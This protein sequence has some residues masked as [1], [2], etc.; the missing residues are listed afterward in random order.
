MSGGAGVDHELV[1]RGRELARIRAFVTGLHDQAGALVVAGAPGAGKTALLDAGAA[2]AQAAGH[3]VVRAAGVRL[4]TGLAY[5][6]LHQILFPLRDRFAALPRP[7]R[8][9]LEIGLGQRPGHRVIAEAMSELWR[10]LSAGRPLLVI[11]DDLPWVDR[12][13]AIVLSHVARGPTGGFLGASRAGLSS[14]F[15]PVGLPELALDP[16]DDAAAEDLLDQRR[17]KLTAEARKRVRAEARGNPLVLLE[18]PAAPAA[19]PRRLREMFTPH[20]R[21]LTPAARRLLLLAAL[22]TTGDQRIL[23]GA[24]ELAELDR[25][26]LLWFDAGRGRLAFRHPLVRSTVL[27]TAGGAELR[28]AHQ[29]LASLFTDQPDRSAWHLAE[30]TVWPDESVAGMLEESARSVLLRGDAVRAVTALERAAGLSP[31]R[32]QR[33]RRLAEAAYLGADLTGGLQ[34]AAKLLADHATT[35]NS[36][37]VAVAAAHVLLNGD[38]DIDTAHRLLVEAI[39]EPSGAFLEDALYTLLLICFFG[40]RAALWVPLR[41]A[42]DKWD[43]QVTA[44]VRLSADTLAD[45]ARTSPAT[46]RRLDTAIEALAGESHP[47]RIIRVALAG[48]FVDR[49]ADCREALWR[50]VRH[51]HEAGVLAAALNARM[52]L[53]RDAYWAGEWDEARQLATGAVAEC[54]ERGYVLLAWPGRHVDA[55]VA[56]ARGEDEAALSAAAEMLWWAGPRDVRLVQCYAWQVQMLAALGRGDF[57]QA[58]RYGNKISPAGT[59]ASHVPYALPVQLDLVEAAVRSGHLAAATAHVEAI[60]TAGTA[61]LSPRLALLAHSAAAL[62]APDDEAAELFERA[63]AVPGA[64]RWPFDLA[65]TNLLYGERLRRTRAVA[66]ARSHLRAAELVF[67]QLGARPWSRRAGAELRAASVAPAGRTLTPQESEIARLAASG[68]RN[69]QI[70]ERLF[71]SPGTVKFHLH[72]V[73]SKLG[74]GSRAALSDA[75]AGLDTD[76]PLADQNI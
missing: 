73:F 49:T 24:A 37:P 67:D 4:E 40:G 47:A 48:Q 56:A 1:G 21:G 54:R 3:T 70:G 66:G 11:V 27:T 45:P 68:L 52:L 2:L 59:L 75:L 69:K 19:L 64:E 62:V 13:S 10:N 25:A 28:A 63:L 39:A 16:L 33:D 65:R 32:D 31:D 61:R 23:D 12:D 34:P 9:A 57:D 44:V 18:L 60:R 55:L 50:I 74:I 15:D 20:V 35:R 17:P 38:G 51:E 30:A 5:A 76:A 26:H 22:D 53:S 43:D 58:H 46:L 7:Q 6:T 8:A 42:L 36:L 72:H 41:E 14:F 71:L 29:Q